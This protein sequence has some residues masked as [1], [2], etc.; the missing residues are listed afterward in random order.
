MPSKLCEDLR[1]GDIN[2]KEVLENQAKFE[3]GLRK[4]KTR[5][6]KLRKQKKQNKEYY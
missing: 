5:G 6:R 3:S 1:D 4:I 2:P